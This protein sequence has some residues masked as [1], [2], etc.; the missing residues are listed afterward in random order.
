MHNEEVGSTPEIDSQAERIYVL[1]LLEGIPEDDIRI[2]ILAD[3]NNRASLDNKSYDDGGKNVVKVAEHLATRREVSLMAACILGPDNIIKRPPAFKQKIAHAFQLLA[4]RIENQGTLVKDGI[5]M[6]AYG[7]LESMSQMSEADAQLVDAI[8]RTC[9]KTSDIKDPSLLLLLGVNYDEDMAYDLGIHAIY[10]SGMDSHTFEDMRVFRSSNISVYPGILNFSSETLWPYVGLQEIDDVVDTVRNQ[11]SPFFRLGYDLPET[12]GFVDTFDSVNRILAGAP[13]Q[14]SIPYSC[15]TAHLLQA[16]K[17][18]YAREKPNILIRV[19]GKYGDVCFEPD[20]PTTYEVHLLHGAHLDPDQMY[21]AI[22]APGQTEGYTQL[23]AFPPIGYANVFQCD[24]SRES[25]RSSVMRIID[26]SRNHE[27]LQGAERIPEIRDLPEFRH[28]FRYAQILQERPDDSLEKIA[29]DLLQ[30]EDNGDERRD[31]LLHYNEVADLFAASMVEWSDK[32]GILWPSAPAFRAFINYVFTSFFFAYYPEHPEWEEKLQKDWRRRAE[33]LSKYMVLTYAMDDFIFDVPPD[34][35]TDKEQFLVTS[36]QLLLR[37]IQQEALNPEEMSEC[38]DILALLLREF[39]DLAQ[40]LRQD[41]TPQTFHYWQEG[42]TDIVQCMHGE[43]L[44]KVTQ[45]DLLERIDSSQEARDMFE[46]TYLSSKVPQP[47]RL[48]IE[49]SYQEYQQSGQK[50][51]AEIDLRLYMYLVDIEKSIGSGNIYKTMA[52]IGSLHE[53]VDEQTMEELD[54]LCAL[55]NYYFRIANDLAEFSRAAD[56]RDENMSSLQ[57]VAAKY[58][59]EEDA[60]QRSF[61][62]VYQLMT[63]LRSDLYNEIDRF[64]K[65]HAGSSLL[66]SLGVALQRARIGEL[67]YK[68]THYRETRRPQVQDFFTQLKNCGINSA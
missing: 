53:P 23:P 66:T 11:V 17:E 24:R 64:Q 40:E 67:F 19:E 12:L 32:A 3:G 15:S 48:K 49:R 62:D 10:R 2:L 22:V 47:V 14:L 60:Q 41:S 26:F 51:D 42:M 21:D 33:L 46:Q 8:R 68:G 45:N 9:E 59:G 37:A 54:A 58:K 6:E 50:Q 5:R 34:Q 18:K 27:A 30:G 16:L 65:E 44:Q 61:Q 38:P 13:V 25:I 55:I 20:D 57:I 31:A 35:Q 28:Y 43:W 4:S 36:T 29:T 56:D 39:Q 52:C 1:P 7:D 63:S